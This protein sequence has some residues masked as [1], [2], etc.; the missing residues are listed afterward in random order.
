MTP[1]GRR[2]F[3]ALLGAGLTG[4]AGVVTGCSDSDGVTSTPSG[5]AGSGGTLAGV[6]FAVRRD[7]G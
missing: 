7:P 3:V 6:S 1:I 2:G 5:A 4:A